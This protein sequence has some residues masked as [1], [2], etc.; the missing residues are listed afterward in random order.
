MGIRSNTSTILFFML[1]TWGYKFLVNN[2]FN[3]EIFGTCPDITTLSLITSA[4][5]RKTAYSMIFRISSTFSMAASR[6]SSSTAFLVT[7]SRD[8]HRAHPVPK[9]L[10]FIV[11]VF[12]S[13]FAKLRTNNINFLDV[14]ELIEKILRHFPILLIQAIFDFGCFNLALY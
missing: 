13:S 9:T 6:F 11:S 2:S 14:Q 7:F 5:V 10:I 1:L 12:D 3:S 8:L 4:G